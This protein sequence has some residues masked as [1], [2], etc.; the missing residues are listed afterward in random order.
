[1][2]GDLADGDQA[3]ASRRL[4]D[5]AQ[6]RPAL[7]EVSDDARIASRL[8]ARSLGETSANLEIE[9]QG[10]WFRPPGGDRKELDKYEAARRILLALAESRRSSP[11]ALLDRDQ[12]FAAGWPGVRIDEGSARNRLHVTL[13]KLRKL[14]LKPFLLR[15]AEGYRLD[16]DVPLRLV[17]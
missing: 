1:A 2:F 9:G 13:A 6:G 10:R 15:E 7:V 3:S 8:L 16:P 12:L 14:G 11:A 5:A 4:G 17:D